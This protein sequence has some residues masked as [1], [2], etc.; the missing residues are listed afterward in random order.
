MQARSEV[1]LDRY[2]IIAPPLSDAEDVPGGFSALY[3]VLRR[4]EEHGTLVR[5][6]FVQGFGAAQFARRDTV[7]QLRQAGE[8]HS[9]S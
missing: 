1:L 8:R 7:D 9:W 4:M 3:P 6:M 5:G 2:G